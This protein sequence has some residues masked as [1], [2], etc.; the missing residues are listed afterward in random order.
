MSS[1]VVPQIP[2]TTSSGIDLLKMQYEK[3][4]DQ[5]QR[6]VWTPKSI[7]IRDEFSEKDLRQGMNNTVRDRMNNNRL[8]PNIETLMV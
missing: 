4:G 5:G 3:D 8:L 1:T 7:S 2:K 6:R